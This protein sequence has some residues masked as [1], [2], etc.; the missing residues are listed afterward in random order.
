MSMIK[1]ENIKKTYTNNESQNVIDGLSLEVA[2]GEIIGIIGESG[3]GKTTL[4]NIVGGLIKP[5]SG[6]ISINNKS[7]SNIFYEI[8]R[9]KT[10]GYI[11][12]SDF[13]LPEFMF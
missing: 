6:E 8:D 12:Q 5:D 3:V 7:S 1:I 10:F 13:L 11:F 4:L 9:V 2:K